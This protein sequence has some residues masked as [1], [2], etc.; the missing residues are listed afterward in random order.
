MA[1][2][3]YE[4]WKRREEHNRKV[5][6]RSLRRRQAYLRQAYN[7]M[8]R[9]CT[10]QIE[11]FYA[12]YAAR[13]GIS[14]TEAKA[15]V[16]QADIKAY[17]RKAAKY[18]AEKDF[19]QAANEEMRL[20]NLTMR[21]NRLELLK[22][23][24]NLE[25]TAGYDAVDKYFRGELENDALNGF[26][27]MAGILG[28]S[29]QNPAKRAEA[30][31]NASFQNATFSQRLWQHHDALMAQ[32][33][34][35]LT[36]S[37][38]RGDH[39]RELARTLKKRFDA[40]TY[41]AERLMI[42]ETARIQ[43]DAQTQSLTRNGYEKYV[44]ITEGN[45]CPACAELEGQVFEIKDMQPGKNAPPMHPICRCGIAAAMDQQEFEKWL[46]SKAE[47]RKMLTKSEAEE[48]KETVKAPKFVPAKNIKDAESFVSR[49]IDSSADF[50]SLGVS[51]KGV[52]LDVAN[53][54]N[55]ALNTFYGMF[56]SKKLGG[57]AAPAKNTKLGKMVNAH[58]GYSPIRKSIVLNR[59][60]TKN[61]KTFLNGLMADNEAIKN[62]LE[63]P[64]R[65]DFGRMSARL[66]NVVENAKITGRGTVPDSIQEAVFHELGHFWEDQMSK[67]E[68][69]RL[70]KNMDKYGSKISGYATD[71]PS[72]YLA[73]S[74][75]SY[76]KGEDRI[77][78]EVKAWFEKM[79]KKS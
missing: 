9:E 56:D 53:D 46:N 33:T 75:A 29:V 26:K 32:L 41:A 18:V 54:I 12:R 78:P 25:L 10:H 4:Y 2:S 37:I 65:Y 20:Y 30:L 28:R 3:S 58:M 24:L 55:D 48:L 6:D 47:A 13:E 59:D 38:I 27:D 11:A 21:V 79:R 51:Y 14:I 16:A 60:A 73:E 74:F 8:M 70:V 43:I 66:R 57:I 63:H 5:T 42:T 49:F 61:S 68:W 31:V 45:P 1:L 19:S 77:D 44:Y 71:N 35:D 40:S 39:P 72:E 23:E 15:R 17:E 69:N 52:G 76:M 34:T 64:E 67:D 36:S 50:G 7:D 22:A 62:I